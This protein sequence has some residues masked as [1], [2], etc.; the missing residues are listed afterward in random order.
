M[1]EFNLVVR[2]S[3]SRKII[4]IQG[5]EEEVVYDIVWM[6]SYVI[7]YSLGESWVCTF[8]EDFWVLEP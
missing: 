4:N 7:S 1:H 6:S 2:V 3:S 8:E 5:S